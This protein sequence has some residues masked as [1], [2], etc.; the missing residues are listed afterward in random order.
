VNDSLTI[1]SS[2]GPYSVHFVKNALSYLKKYPEDKTQLIVD[3]KVY[4]LYKNNF[5]CELPAYKTTL[6]EAREELKNI[7]QASTYTRML[8]DRQVRSDHTLIAIGGGIIQDITCFL[9]STL[10]RGMKWSFVPTTLLAQA[11]SSIGSKSSINVGEFKNL[12]GTFYPPQEIFTDLQFLD[13]LDL[14][15]IKSGIGEI[16]KVHMIK[17]IPY[18]ESALSDYSEM[19]HN[20][21]VLKDYIHKSLVFKREM[22]EL[23]EFDKGPRNVMNYGHSFGHAIEAATNFAVPHGIAVTIGMDMANYQSLKM[24]RVSENQFKSWHIGLKK[25]YHSFK[26]VKI[27]IETFLMA[28]SKDKK[29]VGDGLSLI[30]PQDLG[31]IEKVIVPN[32]RE[33]ADN[34]QVF[35][36]IYL[37]S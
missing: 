3:A 21:L 31:K 13:T 1:Q 27:P 18:F 15:D 30:L 16:L 34:C 37:S 24:N 5:D 36:D 7:D 2:K 17:G 6:I 33:F 14:A 8:I 4:E 11:D 26:N 35:L 12:M 25:N 10:F 9:A 32:N 28:I 22:I 23:D 29:N 19:L 20:R